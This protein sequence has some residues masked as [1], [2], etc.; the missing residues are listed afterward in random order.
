ML[1]G[2]LVGE[3]APVHHESNTGLDGPLAFIQLA[4]N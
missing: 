2:P 4:L 1:S 3:E